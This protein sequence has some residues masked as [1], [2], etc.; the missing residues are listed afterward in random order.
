[1]DANKLTQ[2]SVQAIQAAQNTAVEYG[3]SELTC[4]HLCYALLEHDGLV[5]RILKRAG[6]DAEGV[7]R[8]VKEE[9]ERLPRVSGA[10]TGNIYPTAALSRLFGEAERLAQ[11]MKDEYVS[12]EHLFLCLFDNAEGRLKE[13][14]GKFGIGKE[15]FL[16]GLKEVRGN[17]N[18]KSDNPEATYEA[19][20]KYG[21]DLTKQIGRAHV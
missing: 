13:L 5:F 14:F 17:Q 18:V 12:V 20:E 6:T 8:A 4:T 19:L 7:V 3:N 10:G 2:K 1:M 21:N 16:K 9:I 11:G 15:L